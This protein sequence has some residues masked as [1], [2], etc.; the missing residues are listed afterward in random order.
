MRDFFIEHRLQLVQC[1]GSRW[2]SYRD[3]IYI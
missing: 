3:L 1:R 2:P